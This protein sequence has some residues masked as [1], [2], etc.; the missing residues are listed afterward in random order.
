MKHASQQRTAGVGTVVGAVIF[1]SVLWLSCQ[2]GEL[3]CDSSPQW[4]EACAQMAGAPGTPPP[5]AAPGGPPAMSPPPPPPVNA[6]TPVMNCAQWPTVGD[7]DKF[8]AMR[9]GVNSICHGTNTVWTDMQKTGMWQRVIATDMNSKAKV[10]CAGGPLANG[11]N[12]RES[13]LWTKVQSPAT[14]P[15]GSGVPGA[16]MPPQMM[17]EP[18]MPLLNQSEL[19][20]LEGF[21]KAVTGK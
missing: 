10:S 16:T 5:G 2:P 12:W 7:M 8:F 13:V 4:Q 15:G 21:L 14:C 1:G 19:N 17:Y 9:C 20:C 6:A 18:K 3:P 11:A